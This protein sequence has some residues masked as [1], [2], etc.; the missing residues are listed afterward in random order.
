MNN[1]GAVVA[2]VLVAIVVGA[3]VYFLVK[4]PVIQKKT[5]PVAVIKVTPAS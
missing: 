4:K 5:A 3:F 2:I 1:R